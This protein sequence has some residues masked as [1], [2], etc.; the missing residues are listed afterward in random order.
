MNIISQILYQKR[1]K[2]TCALIPFV[3]AGYPSINSTLKVL[4]V[5]DNAGADIIELGIPYIDAL[6]DG[7]MIQKASQVALSQGISINDILMMLNKATSII[8]TPIIIFTYYNP[9][10]VRGIDSFI[11]DIHKN[12]AKGLI[13]PDLPL[14]EADYIIYLCKLYNLELILFIA[15]TSSNTRIAKIL[16]K[17]SECIYL[18]SS[19][20]VTGI[21]SNINIQ[22]NNLSNYIKSKTN[23]SIIVGF[24]ISN[25][26]Q[27]SLLSQY[28]IDGLVIGS[29]LI[30][31]LSNFNIDFNYLDKLNDFC[32]DIKMAI[33]IKK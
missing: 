9:I 20:G 30:K 3:I 22:L 4:G 24:G 28:N 32:K 1:Q 2:S 11:K 14:E 26:S 33:T 18:V 15:P 21:R 7:P 12:G 13:I 31:I 8:K 10:L 23:K 5:L 25:A 16:S 6:A 27:V 19:T 17:S 29:A